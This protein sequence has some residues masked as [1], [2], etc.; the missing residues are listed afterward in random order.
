MLPLQPDEL[1]VLQPGGSP[2]PSRTGNIGVIAAGT[3]LGEAMLFWD[4]S[5]YHP[6]ASEGGHADFGPQDRPRD[7]PPGSYLRDQFGGHVSYERVLSGPGLP[8]HLRVPQQTGASTPSR[9]G[10]PSGSR[11]ATRTPSIAELGLEGD[12][13]LCVAA[14]DLFASIYGA[15]AGNLA[16]RCV[17][18]GGVFLGGGIAPKILP[19]LRTGRFPRRVHRQGPVRR[20]PRRGSRSASPS[21][22]TPRCSAPPTT[23]TRL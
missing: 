19:V 2:T 4:G 9:P 22:P 8:Q 5:R 12:E 13:P 3:G 1:E 18:V 16:L 15:E 21:T 7:R 23:P 6:I 17:A 10:S 11:R 14:V 20:V